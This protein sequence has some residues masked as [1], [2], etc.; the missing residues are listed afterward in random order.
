MSSSPAAT[1][2]S[3]MSGARHSGDE[4]KWKR[5]INEAFLPLRTSRIES[6][7]FDEDISRSSH[8]PAL[9]MNNYYGAASLD[10][11]SETGRTAA[12]ESGDDGR[13]RR[14]HDQKRGNSP[15]D[16][17]SGASKAVKRGT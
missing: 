4:A 15:I 5:K 10:Q 17:R 2:S 6:E 11:K 9:A 12:R 13:G 16:A 8:R 1:P 3:S 14:D 7:I